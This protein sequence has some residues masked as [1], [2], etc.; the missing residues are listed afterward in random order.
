[1]QGTQGINSK[2]L[3]GRVEKAIINKDCSINFDSKEIEIEECRY[4]Q[5]AAEVYLSILNFLF[6]VMIFL[7]AIGVSF[8][9]T[10]EYSKVPHA[11]L[12]ATIGVIIF[13]LGALIFIVGLPAHRR[14]HKII[15]DAENRIQLENF[16]KRMAKN[17][18][19]AKIEKE[20]SD[21][22]KRCP[23]S[24]NEWVVFL[25]NDI[26][27]LESGK[28]R[29]FKDIIKSIIDGNL[30]DTNEVRKKWELVMQSKR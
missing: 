1:M 17:A 16:E 2:L 26:R 9:L 30:K 29:G 5:K 13:L 18:E 11:F 23:L 4:M 28:V 20:D 27:N 24:L 7:M 12:N 22:E 3:D 25:S 14:C 15:L 19:I 8:L 21:K 6:T 10:Y